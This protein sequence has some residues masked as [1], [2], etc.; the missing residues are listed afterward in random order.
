MIVATCISVF[1]NPLADSALV[2]A[3]V[4]D[5][6]PLL[7]VCVLHLHLTHFHHI[8]TSGCRL[9]SAFH[10]CDMGFCGWLL[11]KG[12]FVQVSRS[13]SQSNSDIDQHHFLLTFLT[14]TLSNIL[15]GALVLL[16]WVSNVHRCQHSRSETGG[17]AMEI[18]TSTAGDR[19]LLHSVSR[20]N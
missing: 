18:C 14:V 17:G 9:F 4:K 8:T 5:V 15:Q 2:Q 20:H 11:Y 6:S 19:H 3:Q 16:K 7:P 1:Q 12:P 10:S 13:C